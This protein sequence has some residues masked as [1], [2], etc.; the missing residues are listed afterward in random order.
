MIN[1]MTVESAYYSIHPYHF[2]VYTT[3]R[4]VNITRIDDFR[5]IIQTQHGYYT[6]APT[7]ILYF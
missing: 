7:T 6:V 2:F 3:E 5:Y 4:I 1:Q